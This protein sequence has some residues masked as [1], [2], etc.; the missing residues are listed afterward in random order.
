LRKLFKELHFSQGTIF[1]FRNNYGHE[2][3]DVLVLF[4]FI[5]ELKAAHD[6]VK[7]TNLPIKAITL[8]H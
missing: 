7:F 3:E 5:D 8:D 1:K 6:H 4:D 2:F